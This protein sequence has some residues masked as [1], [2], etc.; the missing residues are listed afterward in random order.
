MELKQVYRSICV[1][2]F[3]FYFSI[4]ILSACAP[5]EDHM[6]SASQQNLASLAQTLAKGKNEDEKLGTLFQVPEVKDYLTKN[7]RIGKSVGELDNSLQVALLSVIAIGEADVVFQGWESARDLTGQMQEMA[8]QL[9]KVE[10]FYDHIG[11]IVGYHQTVVEL[12]QSSTRDWDNKAQLKQP[13][14]TG[15][16]QDSP[17]RDAYVRWGIEGMDK[18]AEIYPVGGAGDRL[19]LTDPHNGEALP[20]AELN[21]CGRTLLELLISDLRGR[22]ALYEK[23]T[24]KKLEVPVVL[25]TSMEKDND[26]R[27]RQILE[28]NRWF[29]RSPDSFHFVVQPLVPVITVDGHWAMAGPFDLYMKPGGHGV[30]WKLMEDQG[31]FEWLR[32]QGKS[33][34][35]VRQINNPLAGED[36]SLLAFTGIGLHHDKAFG[37]ASCPRKVQA[38]EGMV[39]LIETTINGETSYKITNIEY[40][41]FKKN[42]IEDVPEKKGSSYSQYPANTN[43]LFVDLEYVRSL[44]PKCPVPGMLINLKSEA[45]FRNP[46][47]RVELVKA[48]R[49]ESTMQNI[50]DAIVFDS[51]EPE[52]LPVYLTYNDREKTM[53]VTK[54]SFDP[55]NHSEETP[56][57]CFYTLLSLHREL[58][59]QECGADVPALIEKEAYLD[60][61]PN[62][63][64]LF[65]PSLGPGYRLIGQKIRGGEFKN[66]SELQVCISDVD[67]ENMRLAGS[68]LISG[69]NGQT[70]CRLKNVTIN[71]RGI[72]REKTRDYWKNTPVRHEAL[73][74]V[75]EGKGELIA[76]NVALNGNLSIVVPDGFRLTAVEN[77]SGV[78]FK[79]EPLTEPVKKWHLRFND[80]QKVI[81]ELF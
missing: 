17:N 3:I 81:A 76:E 2:L 15:I 52:D 61:G 41:D 47:G 21:F 50:A 16:H 33:K 69:R 36:D 40:T 28:D 10:Q 78:E 1:H 6:S 34:A 53:G 67:F 45:P 72:D 13:P 73:G 65:N 68:L 35:L 39:V 25:M 12:I 59:V 11:G 22:E 44:V 32:K 24:G 14:K 70:F 37:F 49:L 74:I 20:A 80:Q 4:G 58:L 79:K 5:K 9:K 54:K 75:F 71:N 30:L 31:A 8:E 46:D 42:G 43:I 56:E 77:E 60:S 55:Q 66:G 23:I 63:I 51:L 64:F 27:M 57:F 38:A 7:E 62:L 29:G 48:G 18:M 26:K 19:S